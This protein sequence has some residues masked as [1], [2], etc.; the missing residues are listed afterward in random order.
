VYW[1]EKRAGTFTDTLPSAAATFYPISGPRYPLG[2]LGV[3]L[4]RDSPLTIDQESLLENF[5]RQIASAIER[6][7]LNEITKNAIVVE[8]SERLYKT[9]FNSISHEMRT[10]LSAIIGASESLLD[11]QVSHQV[12]VRKELIGEIHEA[13]GRL[14]RIVENFLDMTRLESGLIQPKLDWCD[15]Q[16]LIN[17]TVRKMTR[18]LS[19]HSVTVNASPELPLIRIDYALMEQ[20]LTN[21]LMNASL[22]SPPGSEISLGAYPEGAECIITVADNGAGLPPGAEE[23]VFEKFYRLP[24]SRTGGTGLGLSIARGFVQSHRGTITAER[25]SEGG[26]RFIIRLPLETVPQD[27]E[28]A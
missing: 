25:R 18:E 2:V 8:Q 9:L 10:P 4:N 19:R 3:R 11:Q 24:G 20:V 23:K 5:I 1:N 13:A 28:Q 16:D 14:N 27:H 12:D 6:E 17:A 21:L 7:T 26:T 15:V 22:Y